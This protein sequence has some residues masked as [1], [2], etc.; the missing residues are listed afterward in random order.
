MAR[1]WRLSIPGYED[2]EEI[3][4]WLRKVED[5]VA[6]MVERAMEDFAT[7]RSVTLLIPD[8]CP[9]CRGPVAHSA[10][11]PASN[12]LARC[13]NPDCII[14]WFHPRRKCDGVRCDG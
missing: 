14:D 7:F 11:Y 2:D 4:G 3:Q 8:R 6:P 9:K 10:G 1:S 12:P 5:V 13:I